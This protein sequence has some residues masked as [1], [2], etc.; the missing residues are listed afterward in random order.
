MVAEDLG[1][2]RDCRKVYHHA[3][4]TNLHEFKN[5]A[6]FRSQKVHTK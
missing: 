3:D 1:Y 5:A 4:K 2:V 6:I